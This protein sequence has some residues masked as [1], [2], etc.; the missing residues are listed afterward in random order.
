MRPRRGRGLRGPLVL[1]GPLSAANV[2]GVQSPRAEFDGL[3]VA[4]IERLRRRWT[5]ALREVEFAVEEAPLLPED[6]TGVEVP[7]ASLLQWPGSRHV[8]VVVFRLPLVARAKGR[9]QL[10]QAISVVLA[11]QLGALW[12]LDPED[13]DPPA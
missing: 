6:W 7:L 8:R 9:H 13:V 5:V 2:P 1:P 4:V 3:V 10:A 12:H 11:E